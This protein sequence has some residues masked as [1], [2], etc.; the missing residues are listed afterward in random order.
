A[1]HA[2]SAR[3]APVLVQQL[4]RTPTNG[5]LAEQIGAEPEEVS[6]AQSAA[7]AGCFAPL[8]LDAPASNGATGAVHDLLGGPDSDYDRVERL[9][10]LQPL[11]GKLKDRERRILELRFE[12]EWSQERIGAELGVSQMQVSRLL[13]EILDKLRTALTEKSVACAA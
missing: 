10:L 5:E 12:H 6:A 1:L 7:D 2:R 8:S 11:I 9:M 3:P 4:H 13:R